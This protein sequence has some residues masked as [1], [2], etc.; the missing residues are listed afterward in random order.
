L[1][2]AQQV[3]RLDKGSDHRKSLNQQKI[4]CARG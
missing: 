3:T 1:N 2:R 4:D